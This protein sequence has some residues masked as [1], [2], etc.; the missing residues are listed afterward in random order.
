MADNVKITISN[1][2]PAVKVVAKKAET[3]S[4]TTAQETTINFIATGER[5]ATGAT[6]ASGATG[7]TVTSVNASNIENSSISTSK[8]QNNAVTAD[9]LEPSL[10]N[11]IDSIGTG[12]EVNVNAD[13]NATSGDAEIL[14]KP[15]IP[16]VPPLIDSDT[17]SGA[18]ST[19]VASAE[20]IKTYVDAE[21]AGSLRQDTAEQGRFDKGRP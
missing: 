3:I 4:G 9:K 13:W 20:S 8:I 11:K 2:A 19:N 12:A 16:T 6:G 14:N 21:V 10:K 18:L 17:M 15:S 7:I 5:G 1:N